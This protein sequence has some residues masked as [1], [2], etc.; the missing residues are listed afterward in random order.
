MERTA[1]L[2]KD[3]AI[4]TIAVVNTKG[5]RMENI[6][7]RWRMVM[8]IESTAT[9][10]TGPEKLMVMALMEQKQREIRVG[11]ERVKQ[12]MV[13]GGDIGLASKPKP[14]LTRRKAETTKR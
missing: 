3:A 4:G 12:G 13:R 5:T 11:T 6:G 7:T 9:I 1:K 14:R 10:L 2:E 8:M